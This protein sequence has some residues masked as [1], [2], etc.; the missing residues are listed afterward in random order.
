MKGFIEEDQQLSENNVYFL[1]STLKFFKD[2]EIDV[3]LFRESQLKSQLKGTR[4]RTVA[5]P[6]C[7]F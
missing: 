3:D 6:I 5:N 2:S 1:L 7:S 4:N